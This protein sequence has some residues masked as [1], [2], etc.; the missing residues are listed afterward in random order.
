[1]FEACSRSKGRASPRSSQA[2]RLTT[3]DTR[4][5][6]ASADADSDR[7]EVCPEAQAFKHTLANVPPSCYSASREREP[8]RG[9]GLR[10][11]RPAPHRARA[12]VQE[13]ALAWRQA[14]C[15]PQQ[16]QLA[17][18]EEGICLY[19]REGTCGAIARA[20]VRRQSVYYEA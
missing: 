11:V 9:G 4:L 7:G 13:G 20:P 14:R 15:H 1:M 12:D 5:S 18:C 3:P 19:A 17:P 2:R 6:A 16:R 8:V 10:R